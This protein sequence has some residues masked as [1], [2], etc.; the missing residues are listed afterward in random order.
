MG[1]SV[2]TGIVNPVKYFFEN[3]AHVAGFLFC[4]ANY[5]H[6]W[7]RVVESGERWGGEESSC[8]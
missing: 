6:K 3:P 5:D 4:G 1:K 2:K 7:F 8:F